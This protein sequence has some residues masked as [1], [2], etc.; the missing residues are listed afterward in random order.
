MKSL[1]GLREEVA[2][3]VVLGAL[4]VGMGVYILLVLDRTLPSMIA[5]LLFLAGG[6]YWSV[7]AIPV[8][9][10]LLT[11]LQTGEP[12]EMQLTIREREK[13]PA[14]NREHIAELRYLD[15]PAG[16]HWDIRLY[17]R[18]QPGLALLPPATRVR[19]YGAREQSGPVIIEF[20]KRMLWSSLLRPAQRHKPG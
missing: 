8:A 3:H 11:L 20:D 4:A 17:L 13:T 12:V 7:A 16:D 14:L 15:T 5:A 10:R 6:V 1:P 2:R 19:V 9:R 18:P